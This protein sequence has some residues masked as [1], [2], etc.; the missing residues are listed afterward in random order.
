MESSTQ[1]RIKLAVNGTLMR[2]LKLNG[3]MIAVNAQFL[4]EDKTEA[5]YRLWS[6]KDEHP[7]MQRVNEGVSVNVEVWNVPP[8]GLGQ[9]LLNEPAGLCVGKVKLVSGETV[10]GVLGES[11]LCEGEKEISQYG[12]WREYVKAKESGQEN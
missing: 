11:I 12:G 1:P 3:N 8:E 2:G 4:R 9:I 7:A 5:R 10:L 6:I